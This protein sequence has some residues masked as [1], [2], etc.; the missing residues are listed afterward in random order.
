MKLHLRITTSILALAIVYFF[1]GKFGLSLAVVHPSASAVWPPSGLAL[2]ALLLWGYRLW[3][4]IFIGAFLVNA[5][6]NES[7]LAALGIALGNTLEAA[8]GAWFVNRFANG[9]KAFEGART[10]FKFVFL[11][12]AVSTAVSATVGVTALVLGG[13][14]PWH[15]YALI[16]ITWWLGDAVGDLIIAPL[17][18]IWLTQPY[19]ELKPAR[20]LEA[21]ALLVSLLGVSLVVFLSD[22]LPRAEYLAVLPLLWAAFRFG[23]RG[24]VT[25]AFA[26]SAIALIGTTGGAGAFA[27]SDPNES[28][29][30]LQGFV[31]TMAVASLILSSVISERRRA[32][33]RLQVQDAVSRILAESPALKEAASRIVRVLCERGGWV[34]GAIWNVDRDAH[35]LACVDLWHPPRVELPE[36]EAVTKERTFS[37]GIGLPGRVWGTGQAAWIP[38]LA[39]DAN[40]PRA[41]AARKNGLRSALGFPIKIGDETVGVIECFGPDLREPDDHFLQLASDIGRQLGQFIERKRAEEELRDS[42]ERFQAILDNSATVIYLKDL[43]GRYIMV[44]ARYEELFR[45]S[46]REMIGKTDLDIFPQAAAEKFRANDLCALE[47]GL[48][49]E[50]EEALPHD[51]GLHTYL[52]IKFP[53]RD[54]T[55]AA[56]G[57]AGILTDITDRKRA[58]EQ[59]TRLNAELQRRID[60]FQ[61]LIDT[62]PVGIAVA[63]D[64]ECRYI[65]GNPEFA[66]MLGTGATQ[67]ISKSGPNSDKL[68][69]AVFRDGRE[70]PAEELPMQRACRE[71]KEILDEELDIV[72][73]D[74][75]VIHELC[76]ATPL[77]DE[78]GRVR[79]CIGVF[80]NITERKQA[81]AM[82]QRAKDDLVKANQELELHVRRRTA[83]LEQANAALLRKIEQE[84]RLQEQLRHAQKMESVGTLAGGIAHE[85]NNILNIISGAAQLLSRRLSDPEAAEHLEM[86][87]QTIRRGASVVRELLTLARKTEAQPALTDANALVSDLTK[88]LKQ[89]FPR[90]IEI[91]LDLASNLPPVLADPSQISQALLNLCVNA[92]DAMPAGGR[93]TIST[94]AVA[95][96]QLREREADSDAEFYVC[97]EVTDTGLGMEE[98]VRHRIFE[99][100]FTTK[101]VGE[102]TGLGL[103]I[104]YGIVRSHKGSIEV[105]SQPGCGST[106]RLFLPITLAV[107]MAAGYDLS[108]APAG[109]AG[110]NGRG[111]VLVV[112]DEEAVLCL[113]KD[114][115]LRHGYEVLTAADGEQAI[116]LY[117][118]HQNAIDA[119]LLDLGLPKITGD[120]VLQTLQQQ[121]PRVNVIVASGYIEPELRSRLLQAGVKDHVYKPYLM[122]QILEKLDA[123]IKAQTGRGPGGLG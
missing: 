62:A 92:R 55:G 18:M 96:A 122:E 20:V 93:L 106:F 88:L 90:N 95:G 82:L 11:A 94:R 50:F 112:E 40:F 16:W 102:G 120:Q 24:A 104:V 63:T 27:S 12:A 2:A 48:P 97:I 76:R 36:F 44:N 69:F 87:H 19:P 115:L 72:L 79:G 45:V 21:A 6:A 47:A 38:D 57:V 60:E 107:G 42:K 86:I 117:R 89:T 23:Q 33:Q 41:A 119:V 111:T 83:D 100:F 118:R 74:G 70:V 101:R 68:P 65:W 78:E 37:P 10:T 58:E 99:P 8:A 7:A 26:L 35:V 71:N 81:E 22:F 49:M 3:P 54:A 110:G 66:R 32:E 17:I 15:D 29:L 105:D 121:N 61:T 43:A 73:R 84:K 64:P 31:G 13:S 28:L 123:T 77:R 53:L 9:V 59:I 85:F 34:F 91:E 80:L 103:A 1:T 67:N 109:Q 5:T 113:L 116:D 25:S 114:A 75:Q 98:S 52:S 14:A 30:Q 4:G 51:D 108:P 46:R 39:K 56:Y